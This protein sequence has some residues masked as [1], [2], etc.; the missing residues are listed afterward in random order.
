MRIHF[1]RHELF[2]PAVQLIIGFFGFRF[3]NPLSR[4]L[5]LVL[6][7]GLEGKWIL[8]WH[9]LVVFC[10]NKAN[11]SN[12]ILFVVFVEAFVYFCR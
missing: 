1:F 2:H 6:L 5:F 3:S 7:L 12:I 4:G 8:T 10:K 11:N 9:I